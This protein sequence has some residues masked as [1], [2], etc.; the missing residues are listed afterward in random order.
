MNTFS[1]S[2]IYAL[3]GLI[4]LAI[5]SNEERRLSVGQVAAAIGSPAPYLSKIMQKIAR[6]GWIDATRGPGGG[7]NANAQT[8]QIRLM[9]LWQ[10]IEPEADRLDCPLGN[11]PCAPGKHCPVHNSFVE[12]RD[13]LHKALAAKTIGLVA[14]QVK[15]GAVYVGFDGMIDV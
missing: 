6:K 2:Y 8:L 11:G 4:Y 14:S 7:L 13:N 3:R 15:R 1:A 12:M 9:D 5:F 10:L